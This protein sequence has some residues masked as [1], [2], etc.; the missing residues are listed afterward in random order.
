LASNE[1]IMRLQD[2]EEQIRTSY[3]NTTIIDDVCTVEAVDE[4][5][6]PGQL[7]QFASKYAINREHITS[8]THYLFGIG[9][10]GKSTARSEINLLLREF[11]NS[12]NISDMEEFSF[13]Q[14][15]EKVHELQANDFNPKVI[16]IPTSHM[17]KILE[18]N[19]EN[20]PYGAQGSYFDTIYLDQAT[21]LKIKYSSKYAQFEEIIITTKEA[22]QWK[23][24]PDV[25]TGNRITAKFDWNA[26]GDENTEL[27]VRTIFNFRIGDPNGNAIF[28]INNQN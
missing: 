22:N 5:Y 20:R 9:E 13:E 4:T 28:R 27:I 18:H 6:Q 2:L 23:Y 1:T 17:E 10:F 7:K 14:I 11:R 26:G 19:R 12:T 16:F 24:R 21:P 3:Q 25:E 8:T 15:L